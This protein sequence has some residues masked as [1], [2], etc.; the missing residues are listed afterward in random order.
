VTR[1]ISPTYP[2]GRYGRR[3]SPSP[4]AR[5]LPV[6]LVTLGMLLGL[7]LAVALYARYGDPDLRVTLQRVRVA[8]AGATVEF[9][10]HKPSGRPVVCQVRARDRSGAT[11]ATA[12]VPVPAGTDV[13]VTHTVATDRRPFTADV[14]RCHAAG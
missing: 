1:T 11:M 8:D 10:V 2:P 9:R 7:V 4:L 6:A 3:R 14:P 13:V 5:W 12:D